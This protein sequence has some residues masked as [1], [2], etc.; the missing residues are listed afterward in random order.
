MFK[1]GLP[2]RRE[3][4]VKVEKYDFPVITLEADKGPKTAKT[5]I[6][7]KEAIAA[8]DL[9]ID[10]KL[11]EE[12][13]YVTQFTAFAF[14]DGKVF[15]CNATDFKDEVI[16]KGLTK[17][18]TFSDKKY[19][20]LITKLFKTDNQLDVELKLIDTGE[21]YNGKTMYEL[22]GLT[23]EE[24]ST[25]KDT[26][27]NAAIAEI[28]EDDA[29]EIVSTIDSEFT[30]NGNFDGGKEQEVETFE[31]PEVPN[32]FED[33]PQDTHGSEVPGEED[34]FGI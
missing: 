21:S 24:L 16:A 29:P 32:E 6:F 10:Q 28:F 20:D 17:T 23:A 5:F 27:S 26:S 14:Q 19:Y 2:P 1:F 7:N 30:E 12:E 3:T 31:N 4:K 22:V 9:N 33:M 11:K 8:L 13:K 25:A 15:L 34:E 18:G